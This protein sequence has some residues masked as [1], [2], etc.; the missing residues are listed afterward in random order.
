MFFLLETTAKVY[1]GYL[2]Y[3]GI[4][5]PW[6]CNLPTDSSIVK[7]DVFRLWVLRKFRHTSAIY[8]VYGNLKDSSP[9]KNGMK[10]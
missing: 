4:C 9:P 3:F 2:L 10:S 7:L 6:R 8:V 5:Q 1:E